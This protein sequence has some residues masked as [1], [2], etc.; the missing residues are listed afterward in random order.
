MGTRAQWVQYILT[1]LNLKFFKCLDLCSLRC[2]KLTRRRVNNFKPETS[3][4]AKVLFAVSWIKSKSALQNPE[5]ERPSQIEVPG[6]FH[7]LIFWC[8]KALLKV[9]VM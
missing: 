6:F 4:V 2:L 1:F 3:L 8:K 9:S 5:Y 7:S